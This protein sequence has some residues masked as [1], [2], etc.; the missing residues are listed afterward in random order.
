MTFVGY[1]PINTR[2]VSFYQATG[3]CGVTVRLFAYYA[4]DPS[5]IPTCG[6]S[7]LFCWDKSSSARVGPDR[8]SRKKPVSE[9]TLSWCKGR[10]TKNQPKPN[11]PS[12]HTAQ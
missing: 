10:K 4:E 3:A 12:R 1:I 11:Q 9:M 8:E 2:T 5:L 6:R 7:V